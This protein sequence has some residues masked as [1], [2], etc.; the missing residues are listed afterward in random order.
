[1]E[2]STK[3]STLRTTRSINK[4]NSFDG[5]SAFIKLHEHYTKNKSLEMSDH[6]LRDPDR[7]KKFTL[8]CGNITLDFSKNRIT[9]ET[10]QLL[11]DLAVERGLG[12]GVKALFSGEIV[13]PTE[14]RPA[15]HTA[16]RNF[17][18]K[19]VFVDGIDI[20][21]E[22]QSTLVKMKN[23]CWR[24]RNQHWRG[25]QNRP[26]K[27]VV[28]IG[29]GGSYLGPKLATDALK[30]Y[31]TSRIQCHYLSNVDGS[32]LTEVLKGLDP[33]TTLFIIQSKSFKTQETLTNALSCKK[34]FLSN[35]GRQEDIAKHFCAVTENDQL[36]HEFG[37]NEQCIFPMWDWV[38]GR[39]SLWSAIGLPVMLTIGYDNFRELLLGAYEIDQ[40][41]LNTPL[42]QNIPVLLGLLGIWYTNFF[43][44]DS[45]AILPYDH[46]LH[47]LTDYIQQL[48]TESSGKSVSLLGN[49]LEFKTGSVIWG[50]VGT[51]GQHA[52]H[53][54]LLQGSSIVPCDFIVSLVPH[55]MVGDHH[56]KL[57]ANCISQSQALMTGRSGDEIVTELVELGLGQDE[58]H[59]LSMHKRVEGNRPSNTIV[60]NKLTPKTLGSLLAMYEHKVFVQGHIWGI[61]SFDQWG[62]ELGK[63]LTS[64]ILGAL[65]STSQKGQFDSSTEQL[66]QLCKKQAEL[67]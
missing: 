1:M 41:F 16:L 49:N 21:P 15:L 57:V 8:S 44:C 7:A 30:P 59:S 61:N 25:F 55:N 63:K 17:S 52:Y 58:A 45:H 22:V 37:I 33:D 38:G 43:E 32:D 3:A 19:P 11:L 6:F 54:L 4:P 39:Y 60:L 9:S 46:Y 20:M 23:F 48:D 14:N 65:Q 24:V 47:G 10:V 27:D 62:V 35:G 51:N 26:I 50:G 66:I 36:A 5:C 29:I 28:S 42:D 34:W 56:Q 31:W 40:H 64:P 67:L 13:N 53:Q 12:Q 2:W 18:G